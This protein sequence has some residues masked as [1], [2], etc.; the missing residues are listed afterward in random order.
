MSWSSKCNGTTN[1]EGRLQEFSLFL[2]KIKPTSIK[3]I[4]QLYK[5]LQ[6][7]LHKTI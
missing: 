4:N 2:K 6:N 7:K 3:A 5:V 1:V